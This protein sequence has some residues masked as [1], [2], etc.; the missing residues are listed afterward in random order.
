MF[1][2]SIRI[3]KKVGSLFL[4]IAVLLQISSCTDEGIAVMETQDKGW[5]L[6]QRVQV[7]GAHRGLIGYPEST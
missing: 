6:L 3:D 1:I 5:T 2:N 7:I 4:L